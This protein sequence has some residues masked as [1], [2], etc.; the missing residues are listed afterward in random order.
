MKNADPCIIK[1]NVRYCVGLK[2]ESSAAS[3][4]STAEPIK[5]AAQTE[6]A[7]TTSTTKVDASSTQSSK[8]SS[9]PSTTTNSAGSP[10]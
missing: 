8:T 1:K 5:T 3:P 10:A 2:S 4:G 7:T 9:V 6:R